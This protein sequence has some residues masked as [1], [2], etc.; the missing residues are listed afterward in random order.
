MKPYAQGFLMLLVSCGVFAYTNN[1]IVYAIALVSIVLLVFLA[2]CDAEIE[3]LN[4]DL[5]RN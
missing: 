1:F 4:D 5:R 3:I 2:I